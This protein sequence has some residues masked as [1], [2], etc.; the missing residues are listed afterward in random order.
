MSDIS[1][2]ICLSMYASSSLYVG[3]HLSALSHDK[4]KENEIVIGRNSESTAWTAVTE[5][6]LQLLFT[7]L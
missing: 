1:L 4:R 3:V 5:C 2:S 7:D 6:L